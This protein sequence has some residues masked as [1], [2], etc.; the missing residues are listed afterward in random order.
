M[1]LEGGDVNRQHLCLLCSTALHEDLERLV[2]QKQEV[3]RMKELLM[4]LR[5]GMAPPG[6]PSQPEARPHSPLA[7]PAYPLRDSPGLDQASA[8]VAPPLTADQLVMYST[9]RSV[10]PPKEGHLVLHEPSNAPAASRPQHSSLRPEPTHNVA[11]SDPPLQ[12]GL[13]FASESAPEVLTFHGSG[14]A[15]EHSRWRTD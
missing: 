15:P 1:G 13:V 2:S 4:Q 7:T 11:H 9:K 3:L 8:P 12:E 5:E 10:V 6:L 14:A